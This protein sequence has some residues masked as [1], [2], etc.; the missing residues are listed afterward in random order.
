MSNSTRKWENRRERAICE[1]KKANTRRS[2]ELILISLLSLRPLFSSFSFNFH[3]T[4]NLWPFTLFLL[5][6]IIFINKCHLCLF[7]FQ[8][9]FHFLCQFPLAI[10]N[11]LN[12][13]LGCFSQHSYWNMCPT[14]L[15]LFFLYYFITWTFNL[16][17]LHT[18]PL[19]GTLSSVFNDT[20]KLALPLKTK[21]YCPYLQWPLLKTWQSY[22]VLEFYNT[23]HYGIYNKKHIYL[24]TCASANK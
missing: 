2:H 14:T 6:S 17:L 13:T 21:T 8:S 20:Y 16:G 3:L 19:M 10:I 12:T 15:V 24:C 11:Q 18:P 22:R 7:P 5:F 23:S 4:C 9:L 1:L